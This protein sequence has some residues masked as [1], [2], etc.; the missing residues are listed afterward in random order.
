[1]FSTSFFC[2]QNSLI[3]RT[4]GETAVL[5]FS[6]LNSSLPFFRRLL[7]AARRPCVF[8]SCVFHALVAAEIPNHRDAGRKLHSP[9]FTKKERGART[10]MNDDAQQLPFQDAPSNKPAGIYWVVRKRCALFSKNQSA[11]STKLVPRSEGSK[12]V[13][14]IYFN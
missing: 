11:R 9:F 6:C 12:G 2:R 1:M 14:K 10:V 5:F 7:P 3:S 4:L 8:S 13:R